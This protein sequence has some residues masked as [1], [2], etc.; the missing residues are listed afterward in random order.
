M[1]IPPFAHS[2]LSEGTEQTITRV[3]KAGKNVA[4]L[5]ESA[6]ERGGEDRHV[7]MTVE[8]ATNAFRRGNQDY[9][10]NWA[11]QAYALARAMPAAEL[12]AVLAAELD[13]A[14]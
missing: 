14:R 1:P 2:P 3:A 12:V 9:S 7:G 8:H 11:G 6:I 4:L 5:V 13:A 10:V